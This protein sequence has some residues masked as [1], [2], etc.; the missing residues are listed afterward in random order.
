M[1]IDSRDLEVSFSMHDILM[2]NNSWI[3]EKRRKKSTRIFSRFLD[4]FLSKK[5]ITLTLKLSKN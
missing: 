3:R 4:F 1:N 2:N 5:K